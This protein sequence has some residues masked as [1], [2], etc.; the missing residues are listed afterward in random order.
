[1]SLDAIDVDY[2]HSDSQGNG[3]VYARSNVTTIPQGST[4]QWYSTCVHV[5]VHYE[6]TW[7]L[8]LEAL[9]TAGHSFPVPAFSGVKPATHASASS[10][11]PPSSASLLL[12]SLLLPANLPGT[13]S[14][15]AAGNEPDP[16]RDGIVA[17]NKKWM[18][19]FASGD[20]DALAQLCTVYMDGGWV[21]L[22]CC[23]EVVVLVAECCCIWY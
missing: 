17:A 15:R 13:L 5:L 6:G 23:G 9:N 20:A 3:F 22:L 1:M 18:S 8:H 11:L 7:Y 10:S 16:V 21:G 14:R 4:E 19:T 2:L 12:D